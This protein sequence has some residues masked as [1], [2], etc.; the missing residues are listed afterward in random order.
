MPKKKKKR[1]WVPFSSGFG[2]IG[3]SSFT[4]AAFSKHRSSSL[5]RRGSEDSTSVKAHLPCSTSHN[6][7]PKPQTLP[8]HAARSW[9][10]GGQLFRGTQPYGKW[11][12]KYALFNRNK[13]ENG[14]YLFHVNSSWGRGTSPMIWS[15]AQCFL[16]KEL[17][18]MKPVPPGAQ[19]ASPL[20]NSLPFRAGSE[21]FCN[22]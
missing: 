2:T 17:P 7:C 15:A 20:S 10:Q 18:Q 9:G 12:W 16:T 19:N 11:N 5:H 8:W 14:K 1:I 3:P 21:A 13:G 4:V 22:S 6:D